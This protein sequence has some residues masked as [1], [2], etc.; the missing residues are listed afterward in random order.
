V[1][2]FNYFKFDLRVRSTRH[3]N[4]AAHLLRPLLDLPGRTFKERGHGCHGY[5]YNP[6]IHPYTEFTKR[7]EA[8]EK[9]AAEIGME[10]VFE[11]GYDLEG[12]LRGAAY[13]EADRCRACYSIGWTRRPGK[14]K[15]AV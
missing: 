10:M 4:I 15:P 12:F 6:N 7:K 2:L 9:Y 5:F 14:Q 11:P 1:K 8:L 13:N 3:E